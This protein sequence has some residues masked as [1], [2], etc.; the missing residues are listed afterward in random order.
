MIEPESNVT[1]L[2]LMLY[3]VF[4]A[5]HMQHGLSY[6]KG[7]CLSVCPSVC[8]SVTRMNCDKTNE[9]SADIPYDR[10]IH[11]LFRRQRMVGEDALFYL[12]FWVKVTHPASKTAIFT[13]YSHLV[14]QPLD[15]AKKVQLGLIGAQ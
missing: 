1:C 8:L 6:S 3:L 12:K 10:K 14:A 15:L 7:V 4:T 5:L 13:R 9:S 2:K 11:V